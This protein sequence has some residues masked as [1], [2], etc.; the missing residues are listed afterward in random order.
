MNKL[1]LLLLNLLISLIFIT[2]IFIAPCIYTN[3]SSASDDN[4][5]GGITGMERGSKKARTDA[6]KNIWRAIIKR[7]EEDG[8]S[9]DYI[10]SLYSRDEVRFEPK[11]MPKK[12]LHDEYKLNYDKFLRPDRIERAVNFLKGHKAVF[13]KVERRFNVPSHIKAA[14]L[15]VETDLGNYTGSYRTFNILSSMAVSNDFSKIWPFLPQGALSDN[16]YIKRIRRIM[17]RRSG[18]AYNELR[19]LLTYCKKNGIDPVSIRGSIFGAFGLCQFVPTSVINFGID[20]NGDGKIDLFSLEDALASMA[21]YLVRHGW[22]KYT[23]NDKDKAV[24]VILTYNH[25]RPYAETVLKAANLIY[26]HMN[27]H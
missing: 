16:A 7:L 25:S 5:S 4:V 12:L 6:P 20:F 23:I 9:R 11:I 8:F 22:D 1:F 21:N 27:S 3:V 10:Y 26:A 15:L 14:I 13:D 18:W 24:K 19:A 17:K 2:L